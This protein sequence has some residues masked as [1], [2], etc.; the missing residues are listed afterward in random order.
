[1]DFSNK[2]LLPMYVSNPEQNKETLTSYTSYTLQ[3]V[4]VPEPLQRRYRDFASFREKLVERWPGVFIPNIPHKQMVGSN[5]KEVISMRIEMINRFCQKL[6]LI[7]S[8][9]FILL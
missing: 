4:R 1:M 5:D 7:G 9:L 6:S 3:G 8:L 2:D